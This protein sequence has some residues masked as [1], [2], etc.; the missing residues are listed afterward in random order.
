M[1]VVVGEEVRDLLLEMVLTLLQ[2]AVVLEDVNL[3]ERKRKG[4]PL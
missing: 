3:L 4:K 1:V 2:A